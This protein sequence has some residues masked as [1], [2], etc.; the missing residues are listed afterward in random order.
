MER[1]SGVGALPGEIRDGNID[2]SQGSSRGYA[3]GQWRGL[4]EH[5]SSDAL[6][7]R[8]RWR[9]CCVFSL[10]CPIPCHPLVIS[11]PYVPAQQPAERALRKR[12]GSQHSSHVALLHCPTQHIRDSLL[13]RPRL[14][15]ATGPENGSS[16]AMGSRYSMKYW[17]LLLAPK[18]R[19]VPIDQ[20][21][22]CASSPF[23]WS[24]QA[25]IWYSAQ[26]QSVTAR[27]KRP[28]TSLVLRQFESWA[29]ARVISLLSQIRRRDWCPTL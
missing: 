5:T 3:A 13:S 2:K 26:L 1:R 17:V 19:L 29:K 18:F 10:N 21:P 15:L 12:I 23:L 16:Y 20:W 8:H 14:L 11:G 6:L 22:L 7:L 24:S 25:P 4:P 9:S 27:S 28:A